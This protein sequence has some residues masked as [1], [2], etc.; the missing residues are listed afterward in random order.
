M[1]HS[2]PLEM[3]GW[4]LFN[5]VVTAVNFY[6]ACL[7]FREGGPAP[8]L[9]LSGSVL[10]AI[11]GIGST[12]LVAYCNMTGS[13]FP[14]PLFRILSPVGALGWFLLSLGW[15]L[16]ALRRRSQAAR[17]TELEAIV[18]ARRERDGSR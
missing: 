7:L 12:G 5:L 8:W 17:I 16:F 14:N 2:Y 18:E 11:G 3:L 10:S 9:M 1:F 6:A 13:N 4:L 15:L